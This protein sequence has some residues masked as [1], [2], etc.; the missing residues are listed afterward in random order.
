MTMEPRVTTYPVVNSQDVPSLVM[1]DGLEM[2]PVRCPTCGRFLFYQAIVIGAARAKCK[3]C[4]Q[5]V[6]LDIIPPPEIIEEE[7]EEA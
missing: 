4:Q 5:W 1:A 3:K 6:T 2:A 7:A